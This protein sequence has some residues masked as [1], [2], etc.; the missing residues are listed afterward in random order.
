MTHYTH[1]LARS[2]DFLDPY[3]WHRAV[4]VPFAGVCWNI[5]LLFSM[6]TP[7]NITSSPLNVKC[8]QSSWLLLFLVDGHPQ[9]AHFLSF[10]KWSTLYVVSCMSWMDMHVAMSVMAL[11]V[12]FM[13]FICLCFPHHSALITSQLCTWWAL[14]YIL[15]VSCTSVFS[16]GCPVVFAS[17]TISFL[18]IATSGFI[19]CCDAYFSGKAEVIRLLK[20]MQYS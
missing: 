19:V 16:A 7:S 4:L 12:N 9:M 15:Y 8:S 11:M 10:C 14:V 6:A 17:V 20:T 3:D 13:P 2:L 18:N 5:T 1:S